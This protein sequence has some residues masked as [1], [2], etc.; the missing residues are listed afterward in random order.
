M[1]KCVL[2]T[3]A[4]CGIGLAA[5]EHFHRQGWNVAASMR[6]PGSDLALSEHPGL[7][8]PQLDVTDPKSIQA[9]V[10]EVLERW[11]RIDVLVNNA[12]YGLIGPFEAADEAQVRRQFEVNVFGLM[13]VTRAVLPAMRQTGTGALVNISSMA[14]YS[15]F[16]YYSLYHASKWAVEGF[17]ESLRYELE[18]FGIRV[19]LVEPGV[20]KT[21][22]HTRSK[23]S[24]ALPAYEPR[25]GRSLARMEQFY[26][27]GN[28]AERIA[29]T[30]Y[31][32]ATDNSS[33]L[34]YPLGWDARSLYL[35]KHIAP[36]GLVRR[37]ARFLCVN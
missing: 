32:A 30:I 12:G 1:T 17:S 31:R 33:K 8:R 7:I 10:D 4:S 13:A 16:P 15:C 9:A 24:I 29:E 22:F 35:L 11:G 23:D 25:A 28:S 18:P 26:H 20:V 34:R 21:D 19:K 6:N 2:I 37:L 36:D 27:F 5:A 3:G 14:G